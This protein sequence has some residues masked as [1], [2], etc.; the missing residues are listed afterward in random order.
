MCVNISYCRLLRDVLA[1][2]KQ[3][4]EETEEHA[5]A[6][7][8]QQQHGGGQQGGQHGSGGGQNELLQA[9]AF[10]VKNDAATC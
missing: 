3:E 4:S 9:V 6:H 5:H 1:E 10:V 8:G 2:M 7:Q